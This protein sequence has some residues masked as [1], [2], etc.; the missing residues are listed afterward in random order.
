MDK[1]RPC[2]KK[3]KAAVPRGRG[4]PKTR[5]EAAV[6]ADA[7][8]PETG[9]QMQRSHAVEPA[10]PPTGKPKQ[11]SGTVDPYGKAWCREWASLR[12]R[13]YVNQ[14]TTTVEQQCCSP[15]NSSWDFCRIALWDYITE[16]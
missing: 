11:A 3:K 4:G 13:S 10:E 7:A 1:Q 14:S 9:E 2:K 15:W 6:H 12:R 16:L 5:A 8:G